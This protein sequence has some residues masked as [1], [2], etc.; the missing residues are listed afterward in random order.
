MRFV[1]VLC[2]WLCPAVPR[3]SSARVPAC[4]R[5]RAIIATYVCAG[6]SS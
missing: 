2:F 5:A 3:C 1:D 6:A 4:P